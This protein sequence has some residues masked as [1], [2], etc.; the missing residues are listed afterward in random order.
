MLT[1]TGTIRFNR[2]CPSQRCTNP[3]DRHHETVLTVLTNAVLPL[4]SVLLGAALTYWLN[5]RTRR[6]TYIED[7][8]NAAISAVA[9]CDASKNYLRRVGRPPELSDDDYRTLLSNIALKAVENHTQRAAEAREAVA[10][11]LQYEPRVQPFYNDAEAITSRPAEVI[12]L[13]TEARAA[14]LTGFRYKK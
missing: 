9:I 7:L 11:V 6:R 10:R 14:V 4:L 12:A 3:V 8:F 2:E 5:V 13:L 1:I